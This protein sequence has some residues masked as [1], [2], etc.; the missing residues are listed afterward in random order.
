MSNGTGRRL[1][2]LEERIG[3]RAGVWPPI[4]WPPEDRAA[5]QDA[6]ARAAADERVEPGVVR[7]RLVAMWEAYRPRGATS[8]ASMVRLAAA[9]EGRDV[10][11]LLAEAAERWF[12]TES[13]TGG[14]A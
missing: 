8:L 1:A 11:E 3:D 5:M 7:S 6:I 12:G 9:D 13:G 2:A 10:D 4:G 14:A